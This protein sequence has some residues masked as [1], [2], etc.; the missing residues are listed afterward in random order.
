M[1]IFE[2]V[3]VFIVPVIRCIPITGRSDIRMDDLFTEELCLTKSTYKGKERLQRIMNAVRKG[4]SATSTTTRLYRRDEDAMKFEAVLAIVSV[5][6]IYSADDM[7][8]RGQLIWVLTVF[9]AQL[10]KEEEGEE[11]Y[12]FQDNQDMPELTRIDS[13][14]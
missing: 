6:L 7:V 12:D 4:I 11:G 5:F 1:R 2:I 9:I 13:E 14:Y 3:L 10:E 8:M